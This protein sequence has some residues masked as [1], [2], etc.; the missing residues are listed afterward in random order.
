MAGVGVPLG[1][2]TVYLAEDTPAVR[3]SVADALKELECEA[4]VDFIV[5]GAFRKQE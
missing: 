1:R 3:R 2:L 4:P 5:T